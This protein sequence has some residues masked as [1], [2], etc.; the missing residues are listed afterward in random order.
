MR[1]RLVILSDIAS[2]GRLLR[3]YFE[4]LS[5]LADSDAASSIG[6][7]SEGIVDSLGKLS[8]K[9]KSAKLGDAPIG[10]LVGGVIPLVVGQFQLAALEHELK[11]RGPIIERELATQRAAMV[12]VRDIMKVDLQAQLNLAET[13]DV[14]RPY[15]SD[16]VP[17]DWSSRRKDI[18]EAQLA[19]GAADS[20]VT[21]VD[22]LTQSFVA[23]TENRFSISDLPALVDDINQMA[24]LLEKLHQG[25]N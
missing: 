15:I 2:H 23:L 12:A 25:T 7:A 9:I 16:T 21:A 20:A 3:S 5:D 14:D 17:S 4:A 11:T 19:L 22:H 8:S 18:L 6:K 1:E 24:T 10:D 13:A